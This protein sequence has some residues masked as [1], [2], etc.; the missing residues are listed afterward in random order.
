[1]SSF[2]LFEHYSLYLFMS[3]TNLS[4]HCSINLVVISVP[5]IPV[6]FFPG[7]N[8]LNSLVTTV[9]SV[10]QA[11]I[12]SHTRRIRMINSCISPSRC[13]IYKWCVVSLILEAV[14]FTWIFS[15]TIYEKVIQSI[16]FCN[17]RIRFLIN[18][19]NWKCHLTLRQ[20]FFLLN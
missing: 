2:N 5:L 17:I 16:V 11:T 19:T 4:E 13:W 3:T 6:R 20:E 14:K 15:F 10:K 1:M 12:I 9:P 7:S 8:F 18:Q